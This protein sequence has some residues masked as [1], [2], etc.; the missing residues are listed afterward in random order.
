MYVQP[1]ANLSTSELFS[2][3]F[4]WPLASLRL[5]TDPTESFE[6][7]ASMDAKLHYDL[8]EKEDRSF[9]H[10]SEGKSSMKEE[11]LDEKP[12]VFSESKERV[13]AQTIIDK[14]FLLFLC[15][16]SS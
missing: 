1:K 7:Q 5:E 6:K 13:D 8:E 10:K 14:V 16:S 2:N 4:I 12:V 9:S 3:T 11:E 15:D